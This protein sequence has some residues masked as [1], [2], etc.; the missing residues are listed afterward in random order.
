M[1]GNKERTT[2][3]LTTV[4]EDVQAGPFC[5]SVSLFQH[6]GPVKYKFR[7]HSFPYQGLWMV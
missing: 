4:A 7:C 3:S 1:T 2:A 5:P 6:K